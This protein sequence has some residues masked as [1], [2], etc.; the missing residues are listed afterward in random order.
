MSGIDRSYEKDQ[1]VQT[2]IEGLADLTKENYLNEF[3]QWLDFIKLSPA[4]QIQTRVKNLT[5][6]DLTERL[7]FENQ[8]RGFK[9]SLEKAGEYRPIQLKHYFEP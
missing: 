6:Q 3:A 8:F 7:Y 4:K 2:W 9:E 1:Y 5:S